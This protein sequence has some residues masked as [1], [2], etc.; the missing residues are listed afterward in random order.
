MLVWGVWLALTITNYKVIILLHQAFIGARYR[1]AL[2]GFIAWVV[3]NS[4]AL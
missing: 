2:F 1:L 4:S 3:I